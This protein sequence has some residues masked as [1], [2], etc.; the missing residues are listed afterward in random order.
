MFNAAVALAVGAIPEG[1]PAAVTITLAI[2]VGRMA[3]R[4]AVVRRLPAVETLGSTTVICTDKTGTLTE[5]VMT[6]VEVWTPLVITGGRRSATPRAAQSLTARGHEVS[7]GQPSSAVAGRGGGAVQRR[8][9]HGSRSAARGGRSDRGRAGRARGESRT[10]TPRCFG[11]PGRGWRR[12]RSARRSSACGSGAATEERPRDRQGGR[13][14]HHRPLRPPAGSGREPEP[15]D[16]DS[17]AGGRGHGRQ[18]AAGPGDRRAAMARPSEHWRDGHQ[19]AFARAGG[20]ARPAASRGDQPSR[21][22]TRPASTVKMITGDHACHGQ[23]HRASGRGRASER[24]D[25]P[26]R[27]DPATSWRA[28]GRRA[29]RARGPGRRLRAGVTGAEAATGRC[30]SGSATTSWR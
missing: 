22:V 11:R 24:A 8:P 14:A 9:C 27:H 25:P 3:R 7:R 20:H 29:R 10:T 15:L 21:H 19:L 17:S 6:V 18:R 30:A 23:R 28:P 26:D 5:N 13:R 4:R 16:E 2:G 12:S 1:L